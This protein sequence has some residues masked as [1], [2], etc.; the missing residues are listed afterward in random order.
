[1]PGRTAQEAVQNYIE[2]LRRALGCLDGYAQIRVSSR[3]DRVG[4]V[5][6][7]ILNG[8]DGMELKN[9]GVLHA[10]QSFELVEADPEKFDTS[11]GKLRVSTRMYI[12]RVVHREWE[13]RWHWHPEGNSPE[14][15]PHIHPSMDL[16]AHLPTP[17]FSL[18]EVVEAC[19]SLGARP[20]R[21]DWSAR[22][23]ETDG[24]HKLYRTWSNDPSEQRSVSG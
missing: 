17:R 12:Y 23:A 8:P 14:H 15:R 7:W 19:I 11:I 22:L 4:D 5:G 2:P 9:F 24:I 20:A 10:Q 16:K 3:V 18:E 21:E 13:L 6:A 1:M